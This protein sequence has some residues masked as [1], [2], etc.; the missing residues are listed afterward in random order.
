MERSSRREPLFTRNYLRPILLAMAL[1]CFNQLSGINGILYYANDIFHD[2]GFNNLSGS[3]QTVMIGL[4]NLAATLLGMALIDYVG[5]KTLLLYGSVGMTIC[6]LGVAYIFHSNLHQ[7]R[8]VWLLVGFIFFFA[9]SQGSV[10][11]VYLSEIFPTRVRSKGQSLGSTTHWVMAAII[12]FNF[13]SIAS[14]SKPLPF[15]VFAGAMALQFIVV[16]FFFPE[17]K[18]VSLEDLQ[19]KLKIA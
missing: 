9:T 11:W 2:A 14:F 1:A 6:L 15:L 19:R 5:R 3:L 16:L 10:I 13:K 7:N 4:M 8:L 12:T 17:T 18:R